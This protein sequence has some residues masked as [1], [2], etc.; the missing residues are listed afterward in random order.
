[1]SVRGKVRSGKCHLENSL[2]AKKSFGELS[3]GRTVLW[4]T[5]R[6][7]NVFEEMSVGKMSAGELS[8]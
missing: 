3:V 5:V 6:R 1:M 8:G 4:V 2:L 7:G